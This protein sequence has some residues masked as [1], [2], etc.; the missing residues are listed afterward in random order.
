MAEKK[1]IYKAPALDKGLDILELLSEVETGLNTRQIAKALD[2]SVNE[3]FRMLCVLEKR[4]YIS[5]D[6]RTS[7]YQ[8][9]LKLFELSHRHP[10]TERLLSAANPAMEQLSASTQ[11]SCHLSVYQAGG[12][13]VI[14]RQESPYKMGFSLRLG[15]II[16]IFGSGSGYLLLAYSSQTQQEQI[17]HEC[18]ASA[19]ERQLMLDA[20][21]PILKQGY[22]IGESPQVSGLTNIT[23]PI[24]SRAQ[25][26]IA[27]ITI[28]FLTLNSQRMHHQVQSLESARVALEQVARELTQSLGGVF[29]L[30]N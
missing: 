24:F 15:A 25:E 14:A 20:I 13:L 26:L 28:P 27:I 22:H 11:Q 6:S 16:D 9:S 21:E 12:L 7:C 30:P 17:L 3:I 23:Y 4:G 5:L 19:Q 29:H 2:R 10:P 8:L 1:T 18:H